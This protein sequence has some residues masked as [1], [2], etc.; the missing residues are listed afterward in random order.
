MNTNMTLSDFIKGERTKK[1]WT[2]GQLAGICNVSERTIQRIEN[3]TL[4]SFE[5]LMSLATAFEIDVTSLQSFQNKKVPEEVQKFEKKMCFLESISDG[6]SLLKLAS[7][8]DASNFDYDKPESQ[9]VAEL[10]GGLLQHVHDYADVMREIGPQMKMECETE[11]DNY[12]KKLQENKIKIFGTVKA[13][14]FHTRAGTI[15][16][17]MLVLKIVKI[18][19]PKILKD[20]EGKK[21]FLSVLF[22][23]NS[24]TF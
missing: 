7:N 17:N 13:R 9:E 20:K 3:H 5:T 19:D 10:I 16:L 18:D 21:E 22:Q 2:Q 4:A 12:V 14:P 1:G 24:E 15:D 6:Y 8:A 11:A 23:N